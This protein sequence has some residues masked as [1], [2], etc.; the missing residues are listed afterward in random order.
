MPGV[1]YLLKV[2]KLFS[3]CGIIEK[4]CGFL[5]W[6]KNNAFWRYMEY[7]FLAIVV[8][9]VALQE[10]LKKQYNAKA[11]TQCTFFYSF[12]TA[13]SA[14]LFFIVTSGFKLNYTLE[15]IPYSIGFAASFAAALG[16]S[17]FAIKLGSLSITLLVMS[18]SLI[19]PAFYGVIAL[20]DPLGAAAIIGLLFLFV[21]IFLINVK[22]EK[23]EVNF[24][25]I[26]SL[27]VT[28]VGNGMCSLVQKLQQLRFEGEYKNEFMSVA[29]LIASIAFLTL[30]LTKKEKIASG[31]KTI[32]PF[33]FA[34]GVANGIAN[35]LVLVLTGLI[36]NIIL[37]PVISAGGIVLG[38]FVAVFIYKERLTYIHNIGY[39]I[40]VISVILLNL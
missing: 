36:P 6:I 23:I 15:I 34:G 33:G 21:S 1:K 2:L 25:W 38:F 30:A 3:K 22:K 40:G 27:I 18:Y 35:Y 20:G 19:I 4:I 7:A 37:F 9:L 17:F 14:M 31:I 26:I 16:G 28:F 10:I 13:F 8:I 39:T 5:P 11:K 24:K 12:V 29:L 32:L